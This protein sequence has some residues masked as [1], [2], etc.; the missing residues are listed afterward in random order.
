[1]RIFPLK[2]EHEKKG[3]DKQYKRQLASQVNVLVEQVQKVSLERHKIK[4]DLKKLVYFR[5]ENI[6]MRAKTLKSGISEIQQNCLELL[7]KEQ[8]A[9]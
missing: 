1:M 5:T 7:M 4:Q 9:T 2:S 8:I 6:I 3:H